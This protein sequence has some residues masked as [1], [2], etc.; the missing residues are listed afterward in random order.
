MLKEA[1]RD[2]SGVRIESSSGRE[3]V[4]RLAELAREMPARGADLKSEFTEVSDEQLSAMSAKE[5]TMLINKYFK[6]REED[7]N[8]SEKQGIKMMPLPSKRLEDALRNAKRREQGE[9]AKKEE[10]RAHRNKALTAE[11]ISA[12]PAV[13]GSNVFAPP[14]EKPE[15]GFFARLFG[16][17]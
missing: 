11:M 12:R 5:I 4:V 8:V 16:G 2:R 15:K 9:R 17:E 13:L 6:S 3:S 1:V 14:A 10:V 7:F